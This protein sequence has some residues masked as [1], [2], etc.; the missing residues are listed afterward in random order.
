M[1]RYFTHYW[2]NKTWEINSNS[3]GELLEYIAGNMFF[4]RGV[5]LGDLIYVITVIK[6][7]LF[8]CGK[9]EVGIFC[10]RSEASKILNAE[11]LWEAEEHII[12]SKGTPMNY[13]LAVPLEV[14]KTLK[15]ISGSK[16][17]GLKFR[18]S[19][20]DKLDEQTLRTLRELSVESAIEFDNLLPQLKETSFL[21]DD[22]DSMNEEPI[23]EEVMDAHKYLEGATKRINVNVYER[24]AKARKK[25]IEHWKVDCFICGFNFQETYGDIGKDFIHV[26]H[27]KPLNEINGEYEVDPIEDLRPVC[28]NC[29]AMIHRKKEAYSIEEIKRIIQQK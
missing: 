22:N 16:V 2:A 21:F 19:N 8:L 23:A 14:T 4:K 5:Q 17:S 10:E 1:Q 28:P 24:N 25:C 11:N 12:A 18:S 20:K 29:H 15:F 27:L 3:E 7:D 26:Y 13:D 6:G 9:L